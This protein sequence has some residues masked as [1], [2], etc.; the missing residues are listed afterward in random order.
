MCAWIMYAHEIS[1]CV[2]MNRTRRQAAFSM[3][4]TF[5]VRIRVVVLRREPP[6][7]HHVQMLEHTC[8][9]KLF[10]WYSENGPLGAL[11]QLLCRYAGNFAF[12]NTSVILHTKW[13]ECIQWADIFLV[14]IPFKGPWSLCSLPGFNKGVW[15]YVSALR[16][17]LKHI[18]VFIFYIF[19]HLV[20]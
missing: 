14:V 2:S 5:S 10:L 1:L 16:Y 15:L 20:C 19:R 4:I 12:K 13:K 3:A 6:F 17:L 18:F 7:C 11:A 8:T 9:F